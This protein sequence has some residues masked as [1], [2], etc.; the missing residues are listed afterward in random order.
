MP[1]L[2]DVIVYCEAL[3]ARVRDQPLMDAQVV[4]PFV[5]RTVEPPLSSLVGKRVESVR[6]MGKRIVFDFERELHLVIHLMIAG[7]F[8][9]LDNDRK[10]P[11]R[12][13]LARFI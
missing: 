8:R 4:S 11:A 10:A 5:L 2:P 6:R 3:D 12:I 1:E 13:T 7:R 9:W